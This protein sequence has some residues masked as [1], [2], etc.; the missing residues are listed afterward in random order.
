MFRKYHATVNRSDGSVAFTATKYNDL[1]IVNNKQ[2]RA[3]LT[4]EKR[5]RDLIK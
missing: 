1:Y 4:S 3:I 2:E 5:D